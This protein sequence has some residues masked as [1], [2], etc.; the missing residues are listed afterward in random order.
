MIQV[1][2]SSWCG[3]WYELSLLLGTYK[4]PRR[5]TVRLPRGSGWWWVRCGSAEGRELIREGVSCILYAEIS[6]LSSRGCTGMSTAVGLG[7]VMTLNSDLYRTKYSE[8]PGDSRGRAGI[9]KV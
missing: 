4:N 8:T 6:V 7:L 5:V 9:L 3:R 2:D 1:M